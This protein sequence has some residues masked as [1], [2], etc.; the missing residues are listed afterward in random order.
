MAE[1]LLEILIAEERADSIRASLEQHELEWSWSGTTDGTVV[2]KLIAPAEQVEAIVD[3]LQP[4]LKAT[5]GARLLVLPLEAHA[6][7]AEE[8]PPTAK[9]AAEG[10]E[11][12]PAPSRI[13]RD[14]LY[15][16][17][18]D[19]AKITRPFLVTTVL[20][21][22]VAS[23][24]IA[25]NSPAVVIGAMVIAPLLGPNMALA[26]GTTLGDLGLVGRALRANAAGFLVALVAGLAAGFVMDI[27]PAA[28]EVSS[29][30]EVSFGELLL[31]L[32]TGTAGALAVTTGLAG[33]LVGVMVAVAL[34]P[35]LVIAAGLFV[36]GHFAESSRAFLLV[37]T[38]VICVNLSG[39]ATFYWRGIRP[40]TWWEAKKSARAT[41]IA[42]SIWIGLLLLVAGLVWLSQ[43]D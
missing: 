9:P 5:A 6:P 31:A 25:R 13:S 35:P 30:L 16:D 41:R 1:R 10:P 27:D 7:R 22:V 11:E 8:P 17:V 3:P 14:E 12:A 34:L 28:S 24:G 29:R 39:V 42:L 38:N 21:V 4:L 20:S 37:A 43:A 33:S 40:R 19:Y 26:L 36:Q 2:F 18:S 15:E 32:A 23:V